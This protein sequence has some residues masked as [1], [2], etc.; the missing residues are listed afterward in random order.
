MKATYKNIAIALAFIAVAL[1]VLTIVD[2]RAGV[3]ANVNNTDLKVIVADL[4]GNPLV[5]A[6]VSALGKTVTSGEKGICSAIDCSDAT[7]GVDSSQTDWATVNV[8]VKK[9]GYVPTFVFCCVV[10]VGQSRKLTV[11]MYK[12]DDSD[13]PYVC[14]VESPPDGYI[15]QLIGTEAN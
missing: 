7:N 13:L 11:R 12:A 8:V 15:K 9:S 3:P 10:P 2:S 5:G 4:D 14:Y 1:V 6:Q